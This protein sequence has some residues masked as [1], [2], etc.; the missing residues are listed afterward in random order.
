MWSRVRQ[1]STGKQWQR[2]KSLLPVKVLWSSC[3]VNNTDDWPSYWDIHWE[4]DAKHAAV[5]P[6]SDWSLSI[7]FF[8]ATGTRSLFTQSVFFPHP[9]PP[10][11]AVATNPSIWVKGRKVF[12][13]LVLC[14]QRD[15]HKVTDGNTMLDRHHKWFPHTVDSFLHY[16]M[17]VISVYIFKT[18]QGWKLYKAI[19]V[20]V[21]SPCYLL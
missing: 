7:Q 10:Q 16:S 9:P 6:S 15:M 12:L 21:N 5:Y 14:G 17:N 20:S 3:L 18:L 19:S 2:G 8:P 4:L 1:V 13:Y 11:L